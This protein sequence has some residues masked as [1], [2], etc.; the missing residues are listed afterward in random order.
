MN[1]PGRMSGI[2]LHEVVVASTTRPVAPYTTGQHGWRWSAPS[3][4]SKASSQID[5]RPQS[6]K[7]MCGE[8][9]ERGECL[10][11][12]RKAGHKRSMSTHGLSALG[13]RRPFRVGNDAKAPKGSRPPDA[14]GSLASDQYGALRRPIVRLPDDPNHTL[15][16][17]L[18]SK[19][20]KPNQSGSNLIKVDHT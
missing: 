18:Q 19:W 11:I 7:N 20:I 4:P 8:S 16:D 6:F 9:G 1:K 5:T 15:C 17:G 14:F 2:H 12:S 3:Q 10:D 13:P